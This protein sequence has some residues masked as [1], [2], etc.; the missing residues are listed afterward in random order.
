APVAPER[1]PPD[2]EGSESAFGLTRLF[3]V[4]VL[5]SVLVATLPLPWQA[6][7]FLFAVPA[8]VVGLRALVVATRARTRGLVPLL[9]VG[10]V[11]ALLW[12]LFLGGIALQWPAVL[13]RQ[14]CLE[15]ALTVTATSACELQYEQHVE[16]LTTTLRDGS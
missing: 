15:G 7:A 11:V 2:P 8:V 4:L 5:S 14:E 12:T 16:R 9:A 6:A 3:G 10:G 13:E 1:Q